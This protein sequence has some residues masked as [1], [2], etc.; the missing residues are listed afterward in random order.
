MLACP[1]GVL[2][3][4]SDDYDE[5]KAAVRRELSNRLG[6]VCPGYLR[7]CSRQTP[8]CHSSCRPRAIEHSW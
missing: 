5:R 8:N 3:L 6:E 1:R 4:C 7:S 2:E